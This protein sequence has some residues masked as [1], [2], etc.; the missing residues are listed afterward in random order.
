MGKLA[1]GLTAIVVF[2]VMLHVA[3]VHAQ[4]PIQPATAAVV[5]QQLLE[6]DQLDQLVAPIALY[7]DAL[8][9]GVPMA[10]TYPLEVVQAS[11]PQGAMRSRRR[12]TNRAGTTA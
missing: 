11:E 7:P 8:L 3:S 2:D 1:G 10:S 5:D 9:A 12:P 4:A 6:A